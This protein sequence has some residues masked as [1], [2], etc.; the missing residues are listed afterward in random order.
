M[1]KEPDKAPEYH[2]GTISTGIESRRSGNHANAN[3][4]RAELVILRQRIATLRE[5]LANVDTHNA[6]LVRMMT[7]DKKFT[8]METAMHDAEN[9]LAAAGKARDEIYARARSKVIT[10]ES[11]PYFKRAGKQK[12]TTNIRERVL[13]SIMANV[14]TSILLDSDIQNIA[15]N[16]IRLYESND[17]DYQ[18]YKTAYTTA[19]T[20]RSNASGAFYGYASRYITKQTT[21]M[22]N[23]IEELEQLLANPRKAVATERRSK[24]LAAL[25]EK[26]RAIFEDIRNVLA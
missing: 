14:D 13:K 11:S 3:A 20:E 6:E 7:E 25:P 19:M 8:A 21:E 12:P 16:L 1:K 17:P 24:E 4:D 15:H 23:N 18:L 9:K 10:D 5:E 22:R 2:R 26:T